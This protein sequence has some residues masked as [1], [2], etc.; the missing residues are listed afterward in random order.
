MAGKKTQTPKQITLGRSQSGGCCGEGGVVCM[1]KG[2]GLAWFSSLSRLIGNLWSII[3]SVSGW[4]SLQSW[5]E[6]E[7]GG[8]RLGMSPELWLILRLLY[9]K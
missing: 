2:L 5:E 9:K 6:R 8:L 3:C 1:Y 4:G 7:E